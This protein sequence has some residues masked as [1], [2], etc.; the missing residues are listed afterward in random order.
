MAAHGDTE[1]A[2]ALLATAILTS[3]LIGGFIFWLYW[4]R[5]KNGSNPRKPNGDGR[6]RKKINSPAKR[7]RSR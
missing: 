1:I 7:R 2:L 6:A 4:T 3:L 5:R